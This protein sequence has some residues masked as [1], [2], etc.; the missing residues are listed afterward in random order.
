MIRHMSALAAL[1]ALSLSSVACV[2]ESEADNSSA[3]VEETSQDVVSRS[4]SFETFE[5]LDGRHYFHVV[6]QNGAIV[7]RSQGYAS[8]ASAKDG[9][10]SV[11]DHGNDKRNFDVLEAANGDYYFNVKANN[12]QVIATSQ[13]YASRSSA[14]RGASTVRALIRIAQQAPKTAAAPH[15]ERFELVTGEDGQTY[16][17]LRAGNGE[18]VLAS[19]GYAS[20][21]GANDGIESVRSNG[22]RLDQF[23][24]FATK[25]GGYALRLLAGNG[26]TIARGEVYASKSNAERAARRIV[27]LITKNVETME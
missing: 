3:E 12:G 26:K 7:L 17:H 1:V 19:E 13:L 2:A 16:F 25:D 11:L 4:A 22:V 14:D 21:A 18:I 10:L 23:D 6:A 5:G 27:E 24:V 8:L 20:K 9:V 15:T